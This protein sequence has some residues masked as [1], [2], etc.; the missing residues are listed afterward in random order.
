MKKLL[1]L[2]ALGVAVKYF[3][4]SEKGGQLKSKIKGWMGDAKDAIDETV[5]NGQKAASGATPKMN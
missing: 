5:R 4:D 3:L 1:T 2:L